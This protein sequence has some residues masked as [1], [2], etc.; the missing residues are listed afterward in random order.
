MRVYI[1]EMLCVCAAS[2][3][4]NVEEIVFIKKRH[5]RT[6]VLKGMVEYGFSVTSL[7][8]LETGFM[9]F[10]DGLFGQ[11]VVCRSRPVVT[12]ELNN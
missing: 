3:L 7:L 2:V 12:K 9:V 6:Q 5:A 1:I 11:D 8:V 10:G 4:E